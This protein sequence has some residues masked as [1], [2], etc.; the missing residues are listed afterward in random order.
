MLFESFNI[1]I[2]YR[3]MAC[4]FEI[5]ERYGDPMVRAFEI[6]QGGIA[7][8]LLTFKEYKWCMSIISGLHPVVKQDVKDLVSEELK[9]TLGTA[10][11][12]HYQL[13]TNNKIKKTA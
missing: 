12:L 5:R 8:L 6:V 10:I 11:T 4:E 13:F 2:S 1:T 7:I 9:E 3:N